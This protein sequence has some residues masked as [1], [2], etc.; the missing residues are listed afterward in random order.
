MCASA[1]TIGLVLA[2][3]AAASAG[4]AALLRPSKT[5]QPTEQT[6]I[7]PEE[8][9]LRAGDNAKRRRLRA[10]G[11]YGF[12]STRLTGP[13]GIGAGSYTAGQNVAAQK[14]LGGA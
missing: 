1:L 6:R 5:G 9:A 13:S 8:E 11:A 14:T 4:S 2:G 3:S 10:R 7:S 12:S